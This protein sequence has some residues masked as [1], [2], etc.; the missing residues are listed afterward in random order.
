MLLLETYTV[1]APFSDCT[2][3]IKMYHTC[4]CKELIQI[5]ETNL[6]TFQ[7]GGD[8]GCGCFLSVFYP[9]L[10]IAPFYSAHLWVYWK[11]SLAIILLK[12]CSN[13]LFSPV[14]L[15]ILRFTLLRIVRVRNTLSELGISAF[16]PHQVLP[17]FISKTGRWWNIEP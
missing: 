14:L 7:Y 1:S 16:Q 12:I 15:I 8:V 10:S 11:Q 2:S 17:A 13:E 3:P 5:F 4:M 9:L 6:L